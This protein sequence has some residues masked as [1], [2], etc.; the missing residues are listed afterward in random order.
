MLSLK[1]VL[2]V[3]PAIKAKQNLLCFISLPGIFQQQVIRTYCQNPSKG[4]LLISDELACC[5]KYLDNKMKTG[6]VLFYPKS[7]KRYA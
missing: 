5:P 2:N 1:R 7:S 4:R 6:F 3:F